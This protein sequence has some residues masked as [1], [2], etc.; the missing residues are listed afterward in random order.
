MQFEVCN[1]KFLKRPMYFIFTPVFCF[2]SSHYSIHKNFK[3]QLQKKKI[4]SM[5]FYISCQNVTE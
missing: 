2:N 4:N 5:R 1:Y 3:I